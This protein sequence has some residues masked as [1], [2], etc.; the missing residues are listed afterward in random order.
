MIQGTK[1]SNLKNLV[2]ENIK[3]L[4]KKTMSIQWKQSMENI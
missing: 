4:E 1:Q 2:K 3:D